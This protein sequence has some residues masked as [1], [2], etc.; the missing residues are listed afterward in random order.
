MQKYKAKFK[1]KSQWGGVYGRK[2]AFLV[3]DM[4]ENPNNF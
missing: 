1:S 2:P 4:N 3:N